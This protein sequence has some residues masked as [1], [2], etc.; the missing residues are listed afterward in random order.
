MAT[1]HIV[2]RAHGEGNI[3]TLVKR[4]WGGFFRKIYIESVGSFTI[5]SKTP[6]PH[7]VADS[8]V[9]ASCYILLC[10]LNFEAANM[11]SK[12]GAVWYVEKVAGSGFNIYHTTDSLVVGATFDYVIINN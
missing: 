3:G 12:L 11:T 8:R 5:P 7:F 9:T 2:P 6:N 10:P 4:W 1:N